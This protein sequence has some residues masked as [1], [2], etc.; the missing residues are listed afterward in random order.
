MRRLLLL[1]AALSPALAVA[2][3]CLPKL[4]LPRAWTAC[5]AAADCVLAGD[6]CRSCA[7]PL[8]VNKAHQAEATAKDEAARAAT[9]CVLTC[10]ACSASLTRLTCEAG[11][12]R[13]APVKAGP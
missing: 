10:E 6:G 11:Q 8:P 9:K 2:Q 1:L 7:H 5:A 13:A 12:C 4:E 3:T